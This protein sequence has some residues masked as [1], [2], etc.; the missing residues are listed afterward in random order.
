MLRIVHLIPYDGVG[1]VETAAK[2]FPSFKDE[3]IEFQVDY[4]I[5]GMPVEAGSLKLYNALYLLSCGWR[6]LSRTPEVLI[7][8]LYRSCIVGCFVKLLRRKLTLI[9]FLHNA[10]DS[11]WVDQICTR[12]AASLADEIW[13]D[14]STTLTRLAP[15]F[16][17]KRHRVISFVTRRFTPF[18]QG[19]VKPSFIFWGRLAPQKGLARAIQIFAKIR[20]KIP[21]ARFRIIGPDTGLLHALE[22]LCKSLNIND[23]VVFSGPATQGEI[24]DFAQHACFYLQ[25]S[26]YE[27]MAMSVV[28]A[29]QMGLVP[30]VTPVGEIG[31]YC[32]HG[33][34]A[35]I[36]ESDQQA[37]ED[38]FELLQSPEQYQALRS[39]ASATWNDR[40]LYRDTMLDACHGL[41]HLKL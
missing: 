7:V 4:I 5:D 28:E 30:V 12:L 17:T 25:T 24:A 19:E 29:M 20:E 26:E 10:K 8:S 35:V 38:V 16:L 40:P 15:R 9:L 22:S 14:C 37:V 2:T 32:R 21:S 41:L 39:M 23:A 3:T 6:Y 18:P 13:S 31:C 1:G 27:G 36:V 34:N 33:C 11:H